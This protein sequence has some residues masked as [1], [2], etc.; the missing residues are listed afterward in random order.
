MISPRIFMCLYVYDMFHI[1]LS[2]DSQGSMEC[3]GVCMYVYI[4]HVLSLFF[5]NNIVL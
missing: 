2:C 1:L 4:K 5:L 3:V